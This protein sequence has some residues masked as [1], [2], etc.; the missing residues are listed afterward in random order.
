MLLDPTGRRIERSPL[1]QRQQPVDA[2]WPPIE[3]P[4]EAID[5]HRAIQSHTK[6]YHTIAVAY[7]TITRP[8]QGEAFDTHYSDG[9][10]SE[11]AIDTERAWVQDW[12]TKT[13]RRLLYQNYVLEIAMSLLQR[14][15]SCFSS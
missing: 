5:T 10:A 2:W 1:C 6:S 9:V 15:S 11:E 8:Y 13:R 14:L 3:V 7:Y 12:I 4:G